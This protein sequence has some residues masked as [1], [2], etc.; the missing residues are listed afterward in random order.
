MG[1]APLTQLIHDVQTLR[2]EVARVSPSELCSVVNHCMNEV[3]SLFSLI[4]LQ[5][6][7]HDLS[8]YDLSN[9][10]LV[11]LANTVQPIIAQSTAHN[12]YRSR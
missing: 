4:N 12:H 10:D 6:S 5:C 1:I 7:D 2:A 8:S 9:H 11:T 3:Q